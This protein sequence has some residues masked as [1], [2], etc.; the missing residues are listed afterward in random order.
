MQKWLNRSSL[1]ISGVGTRNHV[2]D[3]RAHWHHLANMV[4]RLC[5]VSMSGSAI[6]GGNVA[7]LQITL[8]NL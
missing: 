5:T 4:E 2:L 3:R 7:C 1:V 6:S 8:G